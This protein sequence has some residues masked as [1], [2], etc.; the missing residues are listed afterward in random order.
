MKIR[1]ILTIICLVLSTTIAFAKRAAPSNVSPVISNNYVFK[2]LHWASENGT[3]QNGGYIEVLDA[4][5]G[6]KVW[7]LQIYKTNYEQH[8]EHDIQD[9]FI[10]SIKIN[11]WNTKLIV[12]DEMGRQ[13]E[14]NISDRS[15]SKTN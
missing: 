8:L 2:V 4:K 7:G 12:T 10:T 13:Y 1:L 11:F 3:G 6:V 14:V 9:V 5:S 15:V